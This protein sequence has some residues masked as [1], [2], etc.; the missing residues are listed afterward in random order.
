MQLINESSFRIDLDTRFLIDYLSGSRGGLKTEDLLGLRIKLADSFLEHTDFEVDCISQPGILINPVGHL[1]CS[2]VS[3]SINFMTE[4]EDESTISIVLALMLSPPR[5]IITAILAGIYELSKAYPLDDVE[6]RYPNEAL[7]WAKTHYPVCAEAIVTDLPVDLP[8]DLRLPE[9]LRTTPEIEFALEHNYI[10]ARRIGV[11][12]DPS[13]RP[14]FYG[15]H[16]FQRACDPNLNHDE[17]QILIENAQRFFHSALNRGLLSP[18]TI[19]RWNQQY[20]QLTG[21]DLTTS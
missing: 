7:Q 20:H 11:L 2:P 19:Y 21:G 10:D 17:R 1:C 18:E 3:T 4:T 15:L 6:N 13:T 8:S 9:S 16:I 14:D 12:L 5:Q